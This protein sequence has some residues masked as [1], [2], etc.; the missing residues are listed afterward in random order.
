M[1]VA[2]QVIAAGAGWLVRDVV[3]DQG[4]QDRVFEERHADISI[5]AVTGGTFQYR[6]AA[7]S[8]VLVPGSLLLGS[9]GACFEC[10]HEHARGD[11]CL[12]FH[13]TPEFFECVAAD[14]PGARSTAFTRPSLPP[15]PQLVPLLAAAEV[16]G[17]HGDAYAFEE[18]AVRLV[19]A[20]VGLLTPARSST[21]RPSA[22]DER[23]I[24]AA[25]RRIE[26]SCDEA[27]P[28]SALAREANLSR[29]H[30]LRSFQLVTGLTP[31]QFVL[32]TRMHRA[33]VRLRSTREAISGIAFA[34]GFNDLSTFN[35]RFR[36]FA[37]MTPAAYRARNA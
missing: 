7:G 20:V 33:A 35:R 5:A 37:G 34:A 15:V 32:R 23:R 25:V 36:R 11:R 21:R 8:A 14:V 2:T 16:A 22:Q 27:L 28:L 1:S 29:Y 31:H 19:G 24:T 3:C 10:G 30:F 26:R 17:E 4:P 6:T 13:F 12:A 9:A 18:L